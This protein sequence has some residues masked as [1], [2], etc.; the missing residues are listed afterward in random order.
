MLKSGLYI[1]TMNLGKRVYE[2][3]QV[4]IHYYRQS[5]VYYHNTTSNRADARE[6]SFLSPNVFIFCV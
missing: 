1:E 5:F 3:M 6:I 2:I 4:F